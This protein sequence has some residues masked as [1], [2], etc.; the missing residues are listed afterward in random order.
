MTV[1]RRQFLKISGFALGG[2]VVY[3]TLPVA[4][5][6]RSTAAAGNDE[7]VPAGYQPE[8][9][10]W[11]MVVDI[12][13][14]IGCRRCL[15]AC[16]E[17]NHVPPA[18][19]LNRTWLERY[20]ITGD[21]S[22]EVEFI[23]R[24][25]LNSESGEETALKGFFVAKLCNQCSNPPCVSVCPVNAT[26]RTA[27]GVVLVDKDR[28]IGCKYCV[29]ACPYGARYLHPETKVVDK[30][31]FCYHRITQGMPPACVQACPT[32]AR[33]FGNLKNPDDPVRQRLIEEALQVIKPSLGT[34]PRVYYR[35]LRDG[36]R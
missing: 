26:F 3:S 2:L 8:L 22:L 4:L 30:C 33:T 32:G 24:T 28:C 16:K 21:G 34:K 1:P 5:W 6:L 14:C 11:A 35:G 10:L 18:L 9:H 27:D 7:I 19:E 17:E 12:A 20:H 15:K 23:N 13:K 36:V 31:T 25:D 29:V